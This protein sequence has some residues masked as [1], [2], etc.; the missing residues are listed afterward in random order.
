MG[1]RIVRLLGVNQQAVLFVPDLRERMAG[2]DECRFDFEVDPAIGEDRGAYQPGST[3]VAG[4]GLH[5]F[6][7]DCPNPTRTYTMRVDL[8][9]GAPRQKAQL[10]NRVGARKIGPGILLGKALRLG[11]GDRLLPGASSANAVENV[12]A[13]AIQNAG[14]RDDAPIIGQCAHGFQRGNCATDSG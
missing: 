11:L 9:E 13:S 5:P 6:Q 2:I 10:A 8:W 4:S 3:T 14:E 7:V 1:R 12:I